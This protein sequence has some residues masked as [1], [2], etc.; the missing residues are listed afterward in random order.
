MPQVRRKWYNVGVADM[1]MIDE[2]CAKRD[3]IYVIARTHKAE[4]LWCF[5]SCVRKEE[6]T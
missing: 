2:I 1:C 5:G 6:T 4:K 3:E